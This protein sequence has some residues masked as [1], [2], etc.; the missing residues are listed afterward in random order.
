[1][2]VPGKPLGFSL[3]FVGKAGAYPN[4]APFVNYGCKKFYRID[5]RACSIKQIAE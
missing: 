3:M 5:P 1:V 4:E 2:F